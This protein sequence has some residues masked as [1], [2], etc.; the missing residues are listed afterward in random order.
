MSD[1]IL[2]NFDSDE[3]DLPLISIWLTFINITSKFID[4]HRTE[5]SFINSFLIG[6]QYQRYK[7]VLQSRRLDSLLNDLDTILQLLPSFPTI[8]VNID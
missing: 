6:V 4:S 2:L 1:K 7:A 5:T 3:I 8:Y